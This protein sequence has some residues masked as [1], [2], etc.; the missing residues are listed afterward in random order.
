MLD[1]VTSVLDEKVLTLNSTKQPAK[2]HL[3]KLKHVL[4]STPCSKIN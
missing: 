2:W 4:T 1:L 3:R